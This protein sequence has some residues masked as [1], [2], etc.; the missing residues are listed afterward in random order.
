MARPQNRVVDRGGAKLARFAR[1][2]RGPG[3]A[4]L[5]GVQ[6]KEA[7]ATHRTEDGEEAQT[8]GEIASQ[9]ELGLG[10]PERSWLRDWVD[11][12]RAQIQ[13]DLRRAMRLVLLGRMTKEQ[14]VSLLGVKYVG[15]IQARISAGIDPANAPS[16]IARKG[17]STPLI[18]TGQF[19]SAITHVLESML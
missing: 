1:N 5:V 17:S 9:H 3:A 10:V 13:E 19:R 4:V 14:A 16:T 7:K 11:E 18:D 6:G 8:V 2:L 12:N 15:E